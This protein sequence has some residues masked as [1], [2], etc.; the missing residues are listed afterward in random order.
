[1]NFTRILSRRIE[2]AAGALRLLIIFCEMIAAA[3]DERALEIHILQ[4]I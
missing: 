4:A 1:M 2:V 3:A